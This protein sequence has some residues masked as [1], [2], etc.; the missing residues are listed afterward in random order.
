VGQQVADAAEALELRQVDADQL[1]DAGQAVLAVDQ[2]GPGLVGAAGE[3]RAVGLVEDLADD[4]LEHVLEGD[5]ADRVAGVVDHDRQVHA[6][7]LEALQQ[8]VR[9]ML[10]LMNTGGRTRA[11]DAVAVGEPDQL[12]DVQH[13]LHVLDQRA[14][15]D[16]QAAVARAHRQLADLADVPREVDRG[17]AVLGDHDVAGDLLLEADDVGQ[18]RRLVG[19][20]EPSRWP[21]LIM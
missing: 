20:I 13:P 8:V 10:W 15:V 1:L 14:L 17:D 3:R 11:G 16:R 19:G 6:L 12:L 21:T 18:Q 2:V 5:H 7:V 4:L 9:R